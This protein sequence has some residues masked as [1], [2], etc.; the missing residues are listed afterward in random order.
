M[1]RNQ[2]PGH[3]KHQDA[4]WQNKWRW[5]VYGSEHIT[6]S[7]DQCQIPL[8]LVPFRL[9]ETRSSRPDLGPRTRSPRLLYSKRLRRQRLGSCVH[10]GT[11]S[12]K[13]LLILMTNLISGRSFDK[14]MLREK[15]PEKESWTKVLAE[16]MG[17]RWASN[18]RK[19]W[20]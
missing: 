4:Y 6:L 11:R 16:G 17:I 5:P 10:T 13:M 18:S 8:Y 20:L 12:L 15:R 3:P 14:L 7:R 19:R 1:R 2:I 9:G